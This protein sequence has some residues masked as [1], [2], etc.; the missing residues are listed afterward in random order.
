[1]FAHQRGRFLVDGVLALIADLGVDGLDSAFLVRSLRGAQRLLRL[2][3][4]LRHF[5]CGAVTVRG[6]RLEPKVDPD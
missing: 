6:H 3:I 4:S 5:E 2:A 1:M